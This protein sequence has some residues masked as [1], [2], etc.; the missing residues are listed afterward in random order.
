M[1]STP[2][3]IPPK[4]RRLLAERD[5]AGLTAI[6]RQPDN[7]ELRARAAWGLGELRDVEATESLARA[8]L[9]DPDPAVQTAARQALKDLL[10]TNAELTITAYRGS[11]PPDGWLSGPHGGEAQVEDLPQELGEADL[12][13]LIMI[14]RHESNLPL[15]LKAIRILASSSDMRATETL[16]EL[17]LKGDDPSLR[18]AAKQALEDRYGEDAEPII[19]SYRASAGE[20]DEDDFL[21]EE[22][23]SEEEQGDEEDW[24]DEEEE[25]DVSEL[26]QPDPKNRPASPYQTV[27]D[28]QP[29]YPVLEEM[30]IPWR[31]IFWILLIVVILVGII[32]FLRL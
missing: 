4:I 9:E 10:G 25:T 22:D 17:T 8:V 32:L 6:L 14:V 26:F 15:R 13:G 20:T 2:A 23:E 28:K 21:E 27:L 29:T 3:P 19:N 18:G 7:P 1:D 11:T 30:G 31:T 5:L 16:A 12:T 24:D